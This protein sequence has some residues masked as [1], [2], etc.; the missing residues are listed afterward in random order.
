MGGNLWRT[1]LSET[2]GEATKTY[3]YGANG[4]TLTAGDKTYTYND[5][6]QQSGFANEAVSASYA[7]SKLPI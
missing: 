7:Y 4:N 6:G 2:V 3:T 5:R 1:L